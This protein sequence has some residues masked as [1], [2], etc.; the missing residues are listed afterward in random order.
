MGAGAACGGARLRFPVDGRPRLVPHAALRVAHAPRLV[1]ER[2]PARAPRHRG[3]SPRPSPAHHRGQDHLH[4]R[5]AVGRP[6]RL[7]RGRGR[8]EPEGVRGLR[9]PPPRAGRA[10]HRGHRGG[11]HA[12]AR[13]ARDLQGPLHL[14]RGREPRSQARAEAGGPPIWI[15]GRSD[16]ALAR[17]GRQGDGWVSYVVQPERY[18]A[19]LE[20][21]TRRCRR[22]PPAAWRASWP[23]IWPSSPWG[24]TTRRPSGRGWS[25]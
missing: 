18:K 6:A 13:H 24:A 19:S 21:I 16:A 14:V 2:D 4:A 22:G 15:G 25:G 10:R 17:A 23:R 1:R 12:L 8:R 3:L 9:D 5:R 11:A 7:R 20:K